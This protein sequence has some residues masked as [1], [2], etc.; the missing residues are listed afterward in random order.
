V[1]KFTAIVTI[2]F[3]VLV[4]IVGPGWIDEHPT[5]AWVLGVSGVLVIIGLAALFGVLIG[6]TWTRRTMQAGA[7]IALKAQQVND[8][9]DARKTVAL[10]AV[11]RQGATLGR[12]LPGAGQPALPFPGQIAPAGETMFL[13]PLSEFGE[14]SF[15]VI[16]NEVP[17]EDA[18]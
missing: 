8:E 12:Q 14:R 1:K 11:M 7:E 5:A 6:G 17:H 15:Q 18:Q 4:A 16:D 13:P 2:I 9:W 3:L 10:G